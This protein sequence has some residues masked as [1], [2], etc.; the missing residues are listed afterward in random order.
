MKLFNNLILAIV[1]T[2]LSFIIIPLAL[3]YALFYTWKSRSNILVFL[4]DIL[5]K[6][7]IGLDQIGNATCYIF[8][9]SVFIK[10]DTIHPFGDIDETISSVIGKNKLKNNLTITG[11][12]LDKI[13]DLTLGEE[14]SINSIE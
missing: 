4:E 14:H 7:A 6:Y 11:V 5:L 9:N 10:D 3:L 8:L 1:A 2:I 13:L 12:F